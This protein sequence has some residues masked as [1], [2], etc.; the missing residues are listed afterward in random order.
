MFALEAAKADVDMAVAKAR[1]YH[2]YFTFIFVAPA[3]WLD[4]SVS[5]E[6]C[7]EF[8][9]PTALWPRAFAFASTDSGQVSTAANISLPK[10]VFY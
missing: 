1:P 4:D 5:T 10:Y 9:V 2:E 8:F 6:R 3:G 7:H